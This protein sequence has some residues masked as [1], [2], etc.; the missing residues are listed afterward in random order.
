MS[1][2]FVSATIKYTTNGIYV[3]SHQRG[4]AFMKLH[5][6]PQRIGAPPASMN[7][8][9]TKSPG[10]STASASTLS[11]I[12]HLP[13]SLRFHSNSS[14]NATRLNCSGA[15]SSNPSRSMRCRSISRANQNLP[16]G[17]PLLFATAS[18]RSSVCKRGA[19]ARTAGPNARRIFCTSTRHWVSK[20]GWA[21]LV[22]PFTVSGATRGMI[23]SFS[24]VAHASRASFSPSSRSWRT[25]KLSSRTGTAEFPRYESAETRCDMKGNKAKSKNVDVIE[26]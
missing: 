26:A 14:V 11:V 18:E 23:T 24:S 21:G 7:P 6:V 12:I 1:I 22:Q 10:S 5:Y 19:C 17:I 16:P 15:C 3:A 25:Q 13:P 4:S 2:S 20:Q 9:F 8:L